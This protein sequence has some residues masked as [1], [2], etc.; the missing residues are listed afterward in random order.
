MRHLVVLAMLA[1]VP[2]SAAAR[3]Q[4]GQLPGADGVRLFYR[5]VGAGPQAIVFV[6]GGPGSNFRGAGDHVERLAS[7]DRTV[8]LYDQ[9]GGGLSEVVSDPTRL[10]AEH[11]VRDLEALRRHFGFERMTLVGLSWGSGLAALYADAHP[12]RVERLLLLS[13]MS[14]TV[15]RFRERLAALAGLQPPADVERRKTMLARMTVAANDDEA[16]ALCR[17]LTEMAFRLYLVDPTPARLGHAA[18]RCEIPAVAIRNRSVVDDATL[19]SL[20]DWNFLPL[21]ARLKAPA[22]VVEGAR[23]NVP[24][25]ATR[26]WAAALPNARLVLIP[27]AGHEAFLDQPDAFHAIVEE[28]LAGQK[29][30]R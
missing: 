23:T 29:G 6:H 9:R 17:E 21:L 8:V 5:K 12:E 26:E 4:E 20:G 24:L 1:A 11:H 18:L 7:G 3:A 28:F 16:K 15:A 25:E 10:T 14:P 30:S 13:P 2:A 19:S 22:L 27:E